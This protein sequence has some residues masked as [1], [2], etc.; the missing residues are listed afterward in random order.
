M[1]P[2][3]AALNLAGGIIQSTNNGRPCY[4]VYCL[5]IH[6]NPRIPKPTSIKGKKLVAQATRYITVTGTSAWEV[7]ERLLEDELGAIL[8]EKRSTGGCR[9][10]VEFFESDARHP[11]GEETLPQ[12]SPHG[13]VVSDLDSGGSLR[14]LPHAAPSQACQV[15]CRQPSYRKVRDLIRA[16]FASKNKVSAARLEPPV[17]PDPPNSE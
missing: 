14:M 15:G 9:V 2:E 5:R 7:P 10:I 4:G 16:R 6:G 11:S 1:R 13:C 12:T 8:I 3:R 17:K